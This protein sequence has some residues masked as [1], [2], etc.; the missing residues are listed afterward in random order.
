MSQLAV[1]SAAMTEHVANSFSTIPGSCFHLITGGV[2]SQTVCRELVV[3]SAK[4]RD[5]NGML[6][7][8]QACALHVGNLEEIEMA[9]ETFVP[10]TGRTMR[11]TADRLTIWHLSEESPEEAPGLVR[12]GL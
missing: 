10:S 11:W 2:G 9:G 3:K 12:R 6:W 4:W 5:A 7:L 8:V 1:I